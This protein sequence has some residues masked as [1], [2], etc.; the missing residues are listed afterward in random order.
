MAKKPVTTI[1]ID[2]ATRDKLRELADR[3]QRSMAGHLRWLIGQ[4]YRQNEQQ[5][6]PSPKGKTTK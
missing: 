5:E 3:E 1:M 6:S 2:P 4:L